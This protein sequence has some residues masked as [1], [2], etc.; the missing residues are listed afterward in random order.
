L[1]IG[2]SMILVSEIFLQVTEGP[3]STCF[4]LGRSR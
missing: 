4:G 2:Q 1:Q 3:G